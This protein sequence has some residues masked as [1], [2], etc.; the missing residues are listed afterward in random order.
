MVFRLW[1]KRQ[2]QL[3]GT[4][5]QERGEPFFRKFANKLKFR[6]KAAK[7]PSENALLPYSTFKNKIYSPFSVLY[8]CC[9]SDSKPSQAFGNVINID[10][11]PSAT[12]ALRAA[13]YCALTMDLKDYAPP[14]PHD[15]LILLNS[16]VTAKDASKH[17]KVGG[18]ILSNNW[19]HNAEELWCQPENYEIVGC[20]STRE[21]KV[22]ILDKR[23]TVA[24]PPGTNEAGFGYGQGLYVFRK[25][26]D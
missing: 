24:N 4:L 19:T 3:P 10:I 18:Y 22:K 7:N 1:S 5:V 2:E 16:H 23:L 14:E 25:I 17:L 15:L 26:A 9:G 11:D 20:I 6:V 8:P 13:G 21:H 12:S